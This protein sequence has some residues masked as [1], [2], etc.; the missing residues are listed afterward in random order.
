MQCRSCRSLRQH[1]A[2]RPGAWPRC[3]ARRRAL[4]ARG[5]ERGRS[6][7]RAGRL[8][9]PVCGPLPQ[10]RR[11]AMPRS[12][13]QPVSRR[14]RPHRCLVRGRFPAAVVDAT[15]AGARLVARAGLRGE[16]TSGAGAAASAAGGTSVCRVQRH[17]ALVVLGGEPQGRAGHPRRARAGGARRG[18]GLSTHRAHPVA[19][20]KIVGPM[21]SSDRH[22]K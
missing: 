19:E 22:R 10:L 2:A 9:Q 5:G 21:S 8:R 15:H 7:V 12:G 17:L 4:R 1:H 6:L 20:L 18:G 3:T 16:P 11:R 14:A 13:P